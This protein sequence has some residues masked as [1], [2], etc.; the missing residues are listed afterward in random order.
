MELEQQLAKQIFD[1][2]REEDEQ[3]LMDALTRG[4]RLDLPDPAD[5][6]HK[7][8]GA[9]PFLYAI[10]R[11]WELGCKLLLKNG[12]N[13][14]EADN[15]G[16][17]AMH[18][19][20]W[21]NFLNQEQRS[22]ALF[23]LKHGI[24]VDAVTGEDRPDDLCGVTP[25]T[26]A[27]FNG[28][29]YAVDLL[30]RQGAAVNW[31]DTD[32]RTA[33]FHAVRV[34]YLDVVRTLLARGADTNIMDHSE[35]ITPIMI[36]VMYM[37]Y[38]ASELLLIAGANPNIRDIQMRNA[39]HL[40]CYHANVHFE[41]YSF[42]INEILLYSYDSIIATPA[43]RIRLA[44][45]LIEHGVQLD[46]RDWRDNTPLMLALDEDMF[47]MVQLLIEKGADTS[48]CTP[49]Q[50][51]LIGV[52]TLPEDQQQYRP[53]LSH[54]LSAIA[55][56]DESRVNIL[57]QSGY[58]INS[59][60]VNGHNALHYAMGYVTDENDA[61]VNALLNAGVEIDLQSEVSLRCLQRGSTALMFAAAANNLS[62][63]GRL[64]Q[65][66]A[67][68]NRRNSDG[69]TALFYAVK[70]AKIEALKLLLQ[71]G[72][73]P[74]IKCM[75]SYTPLRVMVLLGCLDGATALLE[76]GAD[77]DDVNWKGTTALHAACDRIIID[78]SLLPVSSALPDD[79]NDVAFELRFQLVK[80]LVSHGANLNVRGSHGTPLSVALRNDFYSLAKLL[81]RLGAD[82]MLCTVHQQSIIKQ[83]LL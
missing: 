23:L 14:N 59:K 83:L 44:N 80:L 56:G 7:Y 51:D 39:L 30:L 74:N 79:E 4:P 5:E 25:L 21:Q 53:H 41:N 62:S 63:I 38:E 48:Y 43:I 20:A 10:D 31:L 78:S 37:S 52:I 27:A 70:A 68:I 45:A 24:E 66:G 61:I 76:S 32:G 19:I 33:L 49:A 11:G 64:I 40:L 81:L 17:N 35:Y 77:P 16:A 55:A 72:A 6:N 50:L 69:C 36:A 8:H 67:D 42:S 9:T 29:S 47:D 60:T 2:I 3:K 28:N 18:C 12:A 54:M 71:Q 1:A 75:G 26:V 57:I 82:P 73:D 34:L 22:I 13:Q 15:Y 46:A 58:D 65:A